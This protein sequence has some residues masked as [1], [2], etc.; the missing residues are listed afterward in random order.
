MRTVVV[1]CASFVLSAGS[2]V[3]T[4]VVPTGGSGGSVKARAQ[5]AHATVVSPA[6]AHVREIQPTRARA[7]RGSRSDTE[8]R[9]PLRHPHGESLFV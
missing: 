8:L 5:A 6:P 4:T 3:A 9:H 1:M 7:R 2:L